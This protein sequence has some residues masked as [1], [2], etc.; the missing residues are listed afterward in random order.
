MKKEDIEKRVMELA[1]ES[2][3]WNCFYQFPHGVVTRTYHISSPGYNLNKWPRLKNIIEQHGISGKTVLD[4]GCG[5][6]YYSIECAKMGAKHV[7]GTDI[8]AKRIERALFA[9]EVLEV[10]NVDFRAIDLYKDKVE[11]VDLTIGLGLLHRVPDID[12]C[13]S[14]IGQTSNAAILEFK[15]LNKEGILYEDAGG[16]SK[17]NEYNGLYKIPTKSYVM[18]GMKDAGMKSCM[19]FED[20]DSHLNYRRTIM[21]FT[22]EE[23]E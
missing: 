22:K 2:G 19:I 16:K 12:R 5:D 23:I 11:K 21:Y 15:T 1:D 10:G 14:I 13:M 3:Q 7:L 4:I 18:K 20:K 6:G 8:D 17:S 9:K